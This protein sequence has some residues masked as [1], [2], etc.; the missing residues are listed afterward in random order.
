MAGKLLSGKG[1]MGAG[2]HPAE[3]EAVV[4]PGG[5]EGQWHPDLFQK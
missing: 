2:Q 4:C 3:H 1:P 5:Q